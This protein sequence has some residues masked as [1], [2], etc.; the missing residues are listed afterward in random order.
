[1]KRVLSGVIFLPFFVV[2][3]YYGTLPLFFSLLSVALIIGLIEFFSMIKASGRECYPIIGILLGWLFFLSVFLGRRHFVLPALTLIILLVLLYRLFLKDDLDHAIEGISHTLFGIFYLS[4]L[5]SY[6]LLLYGWK[7]GYQ[8]IF[9][10]FF[11]TWMGDTLAY[12]AGSLMGKKKLYPKI[13]GGK[14]IVGSVGGLLGS[15]GGAYIA[16][17]W[18]FPE[19]GLNDCLIL[20]LLL[21]GFGQLGDLCESLIKRSAGVKDSGSIIPG[22]G[23]VLDRIDSIL[24]SAPL[25]YYYFVF[26]PKGA[27]Y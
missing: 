14:T 5:L 7:D 11:V 18:F 16:K 4:L 2:V 6:L 19:L 9:L 12:Y 25:L 26:F 20:G 10:L 15:I 3:V 8:Y 24:F 21:G 13:S 22:H 17:F 1:M 27:C 23:G